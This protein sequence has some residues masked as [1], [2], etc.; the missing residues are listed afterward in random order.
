[1]RTELIA[2][3][4]AFSPLAVEAQ[5]TCG[6]ET[7]CEIES[8][9]YHAVL[10]AEQEGAPAVIWLHGYGGSGAKAVANRSFV[11]GFTERGYALIALDG[12][13]WG[14]PK[15][16]PDWAVRDGYQAY[17]R[18]DLTFIRAAINNATERFALDPNRILL[19]GSSRGA[20]MVWDV[21]CLN[22]DTATA[23]A[24]VSGGF[25][26]PASTECAGPVHLLHTH[27][28]SDRTVPLE[29][30][31]FQN[32]F[33]FMRQAD[34]HA[35]L[36]T[37]RREMDCE[38]R[39]TRVDAS[40]PLWR[41]EWTKCKGGSVTFLLGPGGHGIPKGWTELALDWFE[42]VAPLEAGRSSE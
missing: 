35:G 31:G 37:W 17:P 29:G 24:P 3:A 39:A 20:S 38:Q 9:V 14:G 7:P 4:I 25:W 21:A 41:K 12:L 32:P 33:F 1:M 8:G 30:R 13:K 27:G 11:E 5:P 26:E 6:G 10:P 34:I 18:N 15:S 36:L 2:L 16:K 40:G 28:F 22:P 23:Y 42:S 19:A